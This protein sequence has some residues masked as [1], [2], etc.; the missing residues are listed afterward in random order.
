MKLRLN[1][2]SRD[3]L[4]RLARSVVAAPKET[5]ALEAAYEKAAGLVRRCVET[6]YPPKDM[7]V[8]ARYEAAKIDDCIKLS[9]TA[10][11]VEQ[12]QFKTDTGPLVVKPTYTGKIYQADV[13]TTDA[14]TDWVLARDAH[15]KAV[16]EKIADYHALIQSAATFEAVAEV[17]PEADQL[18]GQFGGQAIA[19]ISPEIIG[20]IREDVKSR[21]QSEA[22]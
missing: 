10:G 3:A 14:V 13:D 7:R 4:R 16:D 1:Q 8:C 22:A 18:R 12:F 9:L 20:R 6:A 21:A 2:S 15:K 11:G 17:W 5:E 19:V